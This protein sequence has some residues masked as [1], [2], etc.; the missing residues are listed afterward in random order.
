MNAL[1]FYRLDRNL[2]LEEVARYL[3]VSPSTVSYWE[4]GKRG[5]SKK[6]IA[7]LCELFE[8]TEED[9]F[10]EKKKPGRPKSENPRRKGVRIRLTGEEYNK[11]QDVAEYYEQDISKIVREYMEDKW[12]TIQVVKAYYN[13]KTVKELMSPRK[14]RTKS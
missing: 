2:K 14:R 9:L 7:K 10:E 13:V 1:R 4:L 8:C 6:R 11:W 12:Q 5:I 3:D